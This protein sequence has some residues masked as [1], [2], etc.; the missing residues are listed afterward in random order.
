MFAPHASAKAFWPLGFRVDQKI[1]DG[2]DSRLWN[3]RTQT[4]KKVLRYLPQTWGIAGSETGQGFSSDVL[5]LA[6]AGGV[7]KMRTMRRRILNG[8]DSGEGS[9]D[10]L[11][12]SRDKHM[13]RFKCNGKSRN[14]KIQ[15]LKDLSF[16]LEYPV[17]DE[18]TLD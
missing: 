12:K 17:E 8:A 1:L 9:N 14:E 18:D 2:G 16:V 3:G 5:P 4:T 11:K 10:A 6:H 15:N 7:R 13:I